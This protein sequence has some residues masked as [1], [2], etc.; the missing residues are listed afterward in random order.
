MEDMAHLKLNNKQEAREVTAKAT[1]N[2]ILVQ[3]NTNNQI[4]LFSAACCSAGEKR[5]VKRCNEYVSIE[6]GSK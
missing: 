3:I 2:Y 4:N 5:A 6:E 1:F